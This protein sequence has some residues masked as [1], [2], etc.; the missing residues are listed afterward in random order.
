MITRHPLPFDATCTGQGGDLIHLIIRTRPDLP[1]EE[2]DCARIVE[3][4]H[5]VEVRHRCDV[6]E[7]A[8]TEVFDLF[9]NGEEGL[10]HLHAVLVPIVAE[11]DEHH[12]VL[13]AEDRLVHLPPILQV[14]QHKRHF[15]GFEV[16]PVDQE[17]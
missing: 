5:L 3:L 9:G 4:V 15:E 6:D 11:A 1:K 16:L 17:A 13:L 7:V 10:V 2:H 14:R 8:D 12:F